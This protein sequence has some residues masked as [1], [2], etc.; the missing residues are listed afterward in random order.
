MNNQVFDYYR[1]QADKAKAAHKKFD[2]RVNA[3][4][5]L[6]LV[7]LLAGGYLIYQ[8]ISIE[9]IWLTEVV[10]ILIIVAFAWLV[11]KQAQFEKEKQFYQALSQVVT[12]EINCIERH[13]NI[14]SDEAAYVHDEHIYTSDLDIF[15]PAS[16]YNLINRCASPQ[17][18]AKLASWLRKK[19][20]TEAIQQRQEAAKELALQVDWM[21]HFKA[22]LLFAKDTG[23]NEVQQL[24]KYLRIPFEEFRPALKTYIKYSPW[25]FFI[26]LALSFFFPA[27]TAITFTTGL[28]NASIVF[29]NSVKVNRAEQVLGKAGKILSSYSSSFKLVEENGF[30]SH[31][32]SDLQNRF[33]GQEGQPFHKTIKHLSVLINRL[34]YRLN[35]FVGPVLNFSMAWDLRQLIDIDS[36]KQ[37]NQHQIEVAFDCLAEYE[38]LISLASLHYNYPTWAFPDISDEAAYTF[39]AE[40]LAHPLIRK[41]KCVKNDFSLD[42]SYKVDIITGSNMAGKSTFL[43]SI[44]I[45]TVLALSGAP[46]CAS[47][48]KLSNMHVFTYMRIKDSLNENTS[49]FKAELNR[50]KLL[51]DTIQNEEKVYFLI[52]EMLRGTNSVDKYLGSKAVIEKLVAQKA[53]GI[54]A[55]HD[56][57]IA[58]LEDKYPDYIRN[59]YFD[60]QLNGQE[61][62]FDYKIKHGECKTFNASVLLRELGIEVG[63]G[64]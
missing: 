57:Q 9:S 23:A 25:L 13:E 43:R 37:E 38:A 53:V 21:Q 62:L 61:M 49:T 10:F 28:I 19:A 63:D 40:G 22:S 5:L 12:N 32:N 29:K 64:G 15:G 42:N 18:N 59:Y 52:D 55:T 35:I 24:F 34:E 2:R 1:E 14:Y 56:L 36:W 45:N 48:L 20:S 60:I 50:L 26:S 16:L 33:K 41:D 4:S 27:F 7:L 3:Y 47:Y 31:L 44:G 54:V 6:R 46:V 30:K 39:I 8:S 58:R 11:S 17:G 51:L